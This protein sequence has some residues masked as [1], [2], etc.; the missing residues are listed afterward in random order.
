MSIKLFTSFALLLGYTNAGFIMVRDLPTKHYVQKGDLMLGGVFPVHRYSP[1]EFCDT[2]VRELGILQR[3][4]AM[5]YAI[6]EI[7]ARNDIL[8]NVTLGFAIFDGCYKVVTS[9]AQALNFAR[10]ANFTCDRCCGVLALIPPNITRPQY[11]VIGVIGSEGS[12]NSVQIARLMTLFQTPQL[13]YASSSDILKDKVRYPHFRRIIPTDTYQASVIADLLMHFGWTYVS[14]IY[15]EG[16]YGTEGFRSLEKEIYLRGIC[17]AVTRE[18]RQSYI[19]TEIDIVVDEIM[20]A[21]RANVV[22]MIATITTAKSVLEAAR[23][24]GATNITW[25][26]SDAWG[27]NIQDLFGFEEDA[28]GGLIINFKS[29]NVQRFDRFFESLTPGSTLNPW[30]DEFWQQ[31]FGCTLGV[32][33]NCKKNQRF[34][35]LPNYRPERT[36]SLVMDSVYT[37]AY[38]VQNLR[39][40][41]CPNATGDEL[42]RCIS[43]NNLADDI[44]RVNFVGETGDISFNDIGDGRLSY[45][46]H[47][48]QKRGDKYELVPVAWWC[49]LNESLIFYD[50][51]IQWKNNSLTP[52]KSV[53]SDPCPPHHQQILNR[54]NLC[55]FE[56]EKCLHFQRT[57]MKVGFQRCISCPEQTLPDSH[58]QTTCVALIPT[59]LEWKNGMAIVLSTLAGLGVISTLVV[60]VLFYKNRNEHIVKAS[61]KELSYTML[62]GI[63]MSYISVYFL[64]AVPSPEK[65]LVTVYGFHISLTFI[66]GALAT[67]TNRI[68]RIFSA[69]KRTARRPGMIDSRSQLVIAMVI[70]LIHVSEYFHMFVTKSNDHCNDH[71]FGLLYMVS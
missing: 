47:N 53:C 1:I 22:V 42:R 56:C 6:N 41:H 70:I 65:C 59:Y 14:V 63:F 48:V 24:R 8:P 38:A 55:C 33:R 28:S 23:R 5:V 45:E 12:T 16:N 9:L 10:I 44:I 67:K 2:K 18:I 52:P 17:F 31:E 69:G 4:E 26:A 71:C 40:E 66:F 64:I 51:T 60:L 50:E 15:A 7:N 35:R 11:D 13:S 61:S 30:F 34:S 25:I 36:E 3:V 29:T 54:H 20:S 62:L 37:F 39:N 21:Y 19:D 43:D 58:N 49:T 57:E 32:D 68:Y 46:I 27:R